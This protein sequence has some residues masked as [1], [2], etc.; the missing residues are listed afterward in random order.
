MKKDGFKY[1]ARKYLKGGALNPAW[2]DEQD[3]QSLTESIMN[4]I[5]SLLDNTDFDINLQLGEGVDISISNKNN[6]LKNMCNIVNTEN[7]YEVMFNFLKN[8][9]ETPEDLQLA[10]EIIGLK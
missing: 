5:D 6:E 9:S 10:K 8:H 1:M 3:A 2:C 7:D 4:A